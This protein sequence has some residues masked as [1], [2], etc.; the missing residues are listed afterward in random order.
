M[1]Y[2]SYMGNLK[3][4][5]NTLKKVSIMRFTPEWAN[6]YI[7]DKRLDL[8][9][10]EDILIKYKN[11]EM[12]KEE[13]IKEF[14]K[15]L[16]RISLKKLTKELDDSVLLCTCKLGTFCHR[17]LIAEYLRSKKIPI[18][19]LNIKDSLK[20]IKV[21][22]TDLL[23]VSRC[24][25]NP[26]KIFVFSDNLIGKGKKGQAVI[27]DCPNAF[28]IPTKRFPSNKSGSFFTGSKS[29]SDAVMKSL[30][31]L[32]NLSYNGKTI[33]FPKNG[34]GTGLANMEYYA[35]LLYFKMIT[36]INDN[37][38][39]FKVDKKDAIRI[40]VAGGRNFKDFDKL[41]TTIDKYLEDKEN[42]V[43]ISGDA[44][45][46]DKLGLRYAKQNKIEYE[47]YPANWEKHGKSAGFIRNAEMSDIATDLI[48][49]H[50]NKSKGTKHMIET[51]RKK[52]LKV[53]I[54][55]Y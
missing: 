54:I 47:V 51:A 46:A 10:K 38:I 52:K 28:G 30:I 39:N 21:E 15:I 50:D 8:A 48:A 12:T 22:E 29:D 41:S 55:K 31:K 20:A 27:R 53:T 17:H 16:S 32:R 36:F 11:K 26:N 42:V 5:P 7:D 19:E 43:I 45:G 34:V 14:N 18:M 6:K 49:F 37:F 44:K 3:N 23:T 40:I 1:I 24:N 13:Y 9:P 4:I 33:V 2:T 35:P 25:K